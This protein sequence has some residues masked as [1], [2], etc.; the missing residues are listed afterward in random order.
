MQLL[1]INYYIMLMFGISIFL[2]FLLKIIAISSIIR[3]F[4]VNDDNEDQIAEQ[5]PFQKF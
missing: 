1:V 4:D 2:L 3:Q 5:H